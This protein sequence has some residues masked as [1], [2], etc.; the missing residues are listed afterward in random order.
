MTRRKADPAHA[1]EVKPD[2][3]YRR[4]LADHT[5]PVGTTR[6]DGHPLSAFVPRAGRCSDPDGHAE[7]LNAA[8]GGRL[9]R[10]GAALV[11][12]QR[13]YG[14]RYVQ[15]VV[16]RTQ[17]I[18]KTSRAPGGLHERQ[19]DRVAQEVTGRSVLR[20]ASD[21]AHGPDAQVSALGGEVQRAIDQARGGGRAMPDALRTEMEGAFGADFGRVRLHTD[22]RADQLSRSL[23]AEAFT[24]GQDVFF[25]RGAYRPDSQHGRQLVAHEL[26]HV[27]QQDAKPAGR[28]AVVQRW[29]R[30]GLAKRHTAAS[31]L[32]RFKA[33][34]P[35]GY[36]EATAEGVD[37]DAIRP[38]FKPHIDSPNEVY[39]ADIFNELLERIEY[40]KTER[41]FAPAA[42]ERGVEVQVLEAGHN[43]PIPLQVV[44][45]NNAVD[46]HPTGNV[47]MRAKVAVRLPADELGDWTIG[48]TQTVLSGLRRAMLVNPSGG[49]LVTVEVLERHNDRRAA[50]T[51]PWYD[52]MFGKVQP[53]KAFEILT[54]VLDDRPGFR[55]PNLRIDDKLL[56]SSG[57]DVFSTWLI[58]R[59]NTDGTVRY[60]YQW[61]WQLEYRAGGGG[62]SLRS[63]TANTTGNGAVL[64][65]PRATDP[66]EATTDSEVFTLP[67]PAAYKTMKASATK[68]RTIGSGMMSRATYT[69]LYAQYASAVSH[70]DYQRA[71][72]VL[73]QMKTNLDRMGQKGTEYWKSELL[74]QS[75]YLPLRNTIVKL[76]LQVQS[77]LS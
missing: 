75:E 25:R 53:T 14:N 5:D 56:N 76:L 30:A 58:L 3:E 51:P 19:A 1:R 59:N 38:L 35:Q 9:P 24:T 31:L 49:R 57:R 74:R 54:V 69:D 62:A 65:G 60:L 73:E 13:Q 17:E 23:E 45:Q 2:L 66:G 41:R 64:A 72:T 48:I 55:F 22:A 4:D 36:A 47:V 33:V 6:A 32:D 63:E 8:S 29:V 70:R 28:A 34:H 7:A 26:A 43:F 68:A 27:V 61:A 16:D 52:T 71:V 77:E 15:R 67:T 40:R 50:S 21:A 44:E 46:L 39:V 37:D 11:A 42:V 18:Q 10:A 20:R 12:L